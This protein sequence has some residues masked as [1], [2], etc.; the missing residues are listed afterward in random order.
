[1]DAGSRR[2]EARLWPPNPTPVSASSTCPLFYARRPGEADGA[3]IGTLTGQAEAH[4]EKLSLVRNSAHT[5]LVTH[6]SPSVLQSDSGEGP[7]T[8]NR[9]PSI[10]F[11]HVGRDL[12]PHLSFW[13]I[14]HC[15]WFKSVHRKLEEPHCRGHT[16]LHIRT[17]TPA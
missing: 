12:S 4:R 16:V 7:S 6:K 11:L 15:Q 3:S 10:N 2:E 13:L 9:I 8:P 1:M 5:F 17:A 14:Q